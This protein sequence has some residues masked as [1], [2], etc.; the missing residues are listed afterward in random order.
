MAHRRN[1]FDGS[2]PTASTTITHDDE[3]LGGEARIDGMRIGVRHVSAMMLDGGRSP[4]SVADQLDVPIARVYEAMTYYY[5]N[6]DEIRDCDREQED[7]R[8]QLRD[9]FLAPKELVE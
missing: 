1:A 9:E 8:Q 4:A 3:I 5:D 2:N 7:A 6:M